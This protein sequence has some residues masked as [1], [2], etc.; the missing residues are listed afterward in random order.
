VRK[1]GIKEFSDIKRRTDMEVKRFR[2][3]IPPVVRRAIRI[4]GRIA[5][6]VVFWI[7]MAAVAYVVGQVLLFASFKIP[8]H[9]MRPGLIDGDYAL[10]WKPILGARVFNLFD[11]MKGE[12]VPVYRL[13][14][15][16]KVQ[17]NDVLVFH[18][19]YPHRSDSI[20]MHI[21]KYYIKRCVALP[22]D[23]FRIDNGIYRVSGVTDTLGIYHQQTK[24]SDREDSTFQKGVFHCFP[25]DSAYPWNIKRFGPLYVPGKGNEV[26]ID[27][28]NIILY[29]NMIAYE[30]GRKIAV[31]DGRVF[32]D[33]EPLS[34]YTFTHDYYF[35]AGDR[36]FDSRDSRYW[37][38]LPDDL[39]VGKAAIIWQ[40]VNMRTKK[41][42]W[43]RFLK[44][45]E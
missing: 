22:G 43:K 5:V 9:S 8:S 38:L 7:C 4:L 1:S 2:E 33:D 29:R 19:P 10:V 30:T 13:P 45:I 35:M 24:L 37:G 3:K 44:K 11:A 17:R 36:V 23:T 25:F 34:A 32:L 21:L 42:R 31:R 28:Q 41:F 40:S 6:D 15:L 20:G 18:F 26:A 39:I 14:G 16:R 12:K 27:T